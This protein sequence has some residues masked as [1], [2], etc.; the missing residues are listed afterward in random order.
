[1]RRPQS[2]MHCTDI[3]TEMTDLDFSHTDAARLTI[4]G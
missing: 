3:P 4:S 2:P 1:M